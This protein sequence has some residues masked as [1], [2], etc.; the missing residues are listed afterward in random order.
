VARRTYGLDARGIVADDLAVPQTMIV[1]FGVLKH[2]FFKDAGAV[3]GA[4][5]ES[6]T[7]ISIDGVST[8]VANSYAAERAA[9]CRGMKTSRFPS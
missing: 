8:V 7:I 1:G 9:L 5:R 3:G 4:V 2:R 6:A